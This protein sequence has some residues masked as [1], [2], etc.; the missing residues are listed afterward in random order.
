MYCVF[1]FS[2]GFSVQL[3]MSYT[4]TRTTQVV[5]EALSSS[6]HAARWGHPLVT[7]S[8]QEALTTSLK[9]GWGKT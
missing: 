2:V 1:P 4:G 7:F 9:G 8:T 3:Q 5:M 6:D